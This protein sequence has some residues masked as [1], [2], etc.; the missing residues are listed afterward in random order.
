MT[1]RNTCAGRAVCNKNCS[2]MKHDELASY[3]CVPL[4]SVGCGWGTGLT[5]RCIPK[6]MWP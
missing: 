2:L 1:L 6:R 5:S 3:V 4:C